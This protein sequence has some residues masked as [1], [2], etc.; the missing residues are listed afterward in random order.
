MP[1]DVHRYELID[2]ALLVTPAPNY[3]HQ[4]ASV[5]LLVLLHAAC[6]TGLRVLSAPFDVVLADDTGV[7]P[8]LLV[9]RRAD[10][11]EKNLPVPPLLAVEILSPSTRA[12]DLLLKRERYERAA[13]ASYW[14]VD[15]IEPSLTAWEL[16]DRAYEQVAHA[17]GDQAWTA[18]APYPL[19]VV[20]SK[21]VD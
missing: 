8:D 13:V 18:K 3:R 21:L 19:T 4:T 11:T 20:P 17:V 7:Q 6:P 12:I 2:G 1:D 14:V 15:P 5:N 9:A 10:F 16:R